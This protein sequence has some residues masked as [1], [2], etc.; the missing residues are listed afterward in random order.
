MPACQTSLFPKIIGGSSGD[1]YIWQIDVYNDNLAVAGYSGDASLTNNYDNLIGVI[2][3]SE[4]GTKFKWAKA[5]S[6][7]D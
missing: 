1:T 2:E 6:L 5:N 7:N 4:A 3:M